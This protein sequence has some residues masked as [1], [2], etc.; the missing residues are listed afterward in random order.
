MP[1]QEVPRPQP[2]K[3]TNAESDAS[4][5]SVPRVAATVGIL[6]AIMV[7]VFFLVQALQMTTAD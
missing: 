3:A 2:V 4:F 5:I 6:V 1:P 7:L